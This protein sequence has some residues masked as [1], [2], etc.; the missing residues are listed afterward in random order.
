MRVV[1]AK[2]VSSDYD[3]SLSQNGS[4]AQDHVESCQ[5]EIAPYNCLKEQVFIQTIAI[6]ER[7]ILASPE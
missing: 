3:R 2:R 4:E 1:I 7:Y 6:V 5:K